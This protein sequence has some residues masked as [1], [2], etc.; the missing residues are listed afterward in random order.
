MF[1]I[2]KKNR[3]TNILMEYDLISW[4]ELYNFVENYKD[5]EEKEK[6]KEK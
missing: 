3:M 5:N 6:E 4:T 1:P 2:N